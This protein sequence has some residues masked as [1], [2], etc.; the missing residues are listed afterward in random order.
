MQPSLYFWRGWKMGG[1]PIDL[2]EIA[3]KHLMEIPFDLPSDFQIKPSILEFLC[4]IPNLPFK[5]QPISG[6]ACFHE[7]YYN[8]GEIVRPINEQ[9]EKCGYQII[10]NEAG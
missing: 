10:V 5:K 9:F 6:D 2:L 1:L 7:F 3:I 4:Q 8:T